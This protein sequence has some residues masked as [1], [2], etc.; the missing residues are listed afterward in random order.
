M[1]GITLSTILSDVG[2]FFSSAIS[3]AGDVADTI[4]SNPIMLVFCVVPL[5]GLG[6]GIFKRLIRVN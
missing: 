3:W 1:E 2:S 6:I 5:V 4:V